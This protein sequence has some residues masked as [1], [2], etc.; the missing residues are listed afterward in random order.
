MVA[1]LERS[2]NRLRLVSATSELIEAELA[3]ISTLEL[4]LDARI[5]SDWPPTFYNAQTASYVLEQLQND[6][7]QASWWS[8]YILEKNQ[9]GQSDVLIGVVGFKGCPTEQ[10][11][12]EIGYE[13]LPVYQ[14]KGY[15]TEA[16]AALVAWAFSH[17]NINSVS[18]QTLADHHAS[19]G[20][21]TRNRF[22]ATG[23]GFDDGLETVVYELS[24]SSFQ[25]Q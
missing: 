13:L 18:A 6:P 2:T 11:Q 4:L 22:I 8:W 5:P 20:V 21:L 14:K 7:S 19:Q 23:Q 3:D 9:D 12:V 25:A 10:G 16:V 17:S 15:A 1:L 24:R